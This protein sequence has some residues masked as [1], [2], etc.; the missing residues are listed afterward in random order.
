M[1]ATERFYSGL[2]LCHLGAAIL[3]GALLM[4]ASCFVGR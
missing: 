3:V 1:N 4:V 2:A